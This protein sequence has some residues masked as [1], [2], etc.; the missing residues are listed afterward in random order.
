MNNIIQ[1]SAPTNQIIINQ[2]NNTVEVIQT[3]NQIIVQ[4]VGI[5]GAKG[6]GTIIS[7]NTLEEP[8][9]FIE[10]GTDGDDFNIVSAGDTHT[11]NIPTASVFKL[12]GLLSADDWEMFNSKQN[13]LEFTPEDEA[14]KAIDFTT[15]NNTLYPSVQAV[16]TE[17]DLKA[18]ETSLQAH[19]DDLNNPHATTK[20]QIGLGNVDNTSDLDKPISTATQ[21]VLDTKVDEINITAG[22]LGSPSKTPSITY[23]EQ[24]QITT[25]SEQDI[26]IA[27]SQVDN[28]TTDLSGKEPTITAGATSQYYRG[29]KTFQTLDTSAVPENTNLYFTEGRT[30]ATDLTGLNIT[31][32][33][34]S[35]SDS[36]LNAFGKVQNQINGLIGGAIYQG[37]WNATTNSPTL[38]PSVGTAGYYYIVNVAGSTNLDGITDWKIGDWAI[39]DG[40]V[41]QKVD[42]TDAVSSVNG[43]TGAVNL[44]TADI[45][46]S[47]NKRYVS[48][49][50]LTV[51][52]N[53]SGTNTGDN[54]TNTTSNAYADAKV[55]DTINNGI[56]TIAPS[57]NAVFDALAGKQDQGNLLDSISTLSGNGIIV[58]QN[59]N[60]A[61]TRSIVAGSSKI[62]VSNGS[63]ASGNPSIDLGTVAI[64]NITGLQTALDGKQTTTLTFGNILVGNGSNLAASV[65]VS[66]DATMANTGTLTI[67]NQAITYAKFQQIPPYNLIGNAFGSNSVPQSITLGVSMA[68]QGSNLVRNGITGDVSIPTNSNSATLATVNTNV[69]SYGNATQTTTFTVNGKGLITAAGQ[70]TIT[71][72]VGSITGLGT[73]VASALGVN[74]GTAGSPIING[75]ALGTPSSGVAT[76]LTG[77]ASGLT[78][79]NV[80][81]NANLVGDVTS[82]GNTTTI[83]ALKVLGSMIA[84]ATIDLVTKVTGI[85]PNANTTATSANTANAIVSRDVS[86]GFSAGGINAST[87]TATG[88]ITSSSPVTSSDGLVI[89]YRDAGNAGISYISAQNYDTTST[90]HAFTEAQSGLSGSG[91]DAGLT[92]ATSTGAFTFGI[93]KATGKINLT[94][95]YAD[96]ATAPVISLDPTTANIALSRLTASTAL[97]LNASKN[98]VSVPYTYGKVLGNGAQFIP[99][100]SNTNLTSTYWNGTST[101]NGNISYSNG[102]FT[103]SSAGFYQISANMVFTNN[104]T[105]SREALIWKNNTTII[106]YVCLNANSS[107]RTGLSCS[108][109]DYLNAGDYVT[110]NVHQS[111]GGSLSTGTLFGGTFSIF[112]QT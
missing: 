94:L 91:G 24:G 38:T 59:G 39:F 107:D 11:I 93:N 47:L 112:L 46:D 60:D 10:I 2:T 80:T 15:V 21:T 81:T 75:G 3:S 43:Y 82:V 35:S 53:T 56:T 52:G 108:A 58:R 26:Q 20:E 42:N 4:N 62:T 7:I 65:P 72:A 88:L 105:G 29:D 67:A 12:R 23:N 103:V 63:G 61:E 57:Q 78:A 110:V 55:A 104:S 109:G 74:V 98:I 102:V 45:P 95:L 79:G 87:I 1:V 30:R 69:G 85:L 22:S 37:V 36:I 6:D 64:A 5:Q 48:D 99:N 33:S 27:Q 77:V 111:S 73:G 44:T 49:A 8:D 66:G 84:N 97:A 92:A 76:N 34:I 13:Q 18:D 28:L 90:S 25:A 89:S 101:T 14:N 40:T 96:T 9:Q 106:G 50:Q 51:L 17:L 70:T 16:Q 32:G 68:I 31:G 71:P 19:I 54:A 83:G 41:W 86:G 100:A